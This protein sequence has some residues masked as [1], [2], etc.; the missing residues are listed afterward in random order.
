MGTKY[1]NSAFPPQLG[2]FLRNLSTIPPKMVHSDWLKI[3]VNNACDWTKTKFT[4]AMLDG[5]R[6]QRQI[7]CR[8]HHL[9]VLLIYAR[10]RESDKFYLRG[11]PPFSL[12][13]FWL[14]LHQSINQVLLG[15]ILLT[16]LF[17]S[18]RCK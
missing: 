3:S 1:L 9:A 2:W 7:C 5:N 18:P 12:K 10:H 16:H 17:F 4:L 6:H 14:H 15:Y 8:S 13:F 11:I